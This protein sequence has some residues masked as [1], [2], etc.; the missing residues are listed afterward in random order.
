MDQTKDD[1][2]IKRINRS[3]IKKLIFTGTGYSIDKLMKGIGA[4]AV[5]LI[6]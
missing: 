4:K 6:F 5:K 2:I 3:A 1:W